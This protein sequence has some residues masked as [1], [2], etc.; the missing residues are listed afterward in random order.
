[1]TKKHRTYLPRIVGDSKPISFDGHSTRS[2]PCAVNLRTACLSTANMI[3][4]CEDVCPLVPIL[5]ISLSFLWPLARGSTSS[6]IRRSHPA[7]NEW[8]SFGKQAQ[9]PEPASLPGF[10]PERQDW[11]LSSAQSA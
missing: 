3:A 10:K 1:M 8:R 11:A 7:Q 6:P 9:P 2:G 4:V 5:P